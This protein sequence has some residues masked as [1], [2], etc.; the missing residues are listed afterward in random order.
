MTDTAENI[1]KPVWIERLA[2]ALRGHGED[3]YHPALDMLRSAGRWTDAA[4]VDAAVLVAI[5]EAAREPELILTRRRDELLQ[6]AGQVAFPGGAADPDDAGPEATALREAEEEI[7][8]P[9]ARVEV[10][11]R[12]SRYPT[13]SGY[14]VAPVVGYV[15]TP[16]AL[17]ASPDEVAD[18][19]TLPLSALLDASLWRQC[20]LELGKRRILYPEMHWAGQRIWGVTAGMLQLLI[21]LLREVREDA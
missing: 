3:I 10:L 18:L 7:A 1:D 16:V 12:L 20:E 2:M 15:R 6:H 19:F 9:A 13:T 14:L 8:L 21:P 4:P 11:G 17:R 5:M